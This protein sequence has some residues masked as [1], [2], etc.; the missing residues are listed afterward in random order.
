MGNSLDLLA[1]SADAEATVAL[2]AVL[3]KQERALRRQY[4]RLKD[5]RK[6]GRTARLE[7]ALVNAP[8]LPRTTRRGP[9]IPR[10]RVRRPTLS[11]EQAVRVLLKSRKRVLV[12]TERGRNEIRVAYRMD[13]G[14]VGLLELD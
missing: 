9:E 10:E 11:A 1:K 13:D 8:P 3:D 14:T 4:D 5:K 12:F 6:H 7:P 2:D